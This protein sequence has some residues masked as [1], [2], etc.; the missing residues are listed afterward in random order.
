MTSGTH[1]IIFLFRFSLPTME[2]QLS[3]VCDLFVV[4]PMKCLKMNVQFVLL[5]WSLLRT[6]K[7]SP[8]IFTFFAL[9]HG[10]CF[11]YFLPTLLYLLFYFFSIL[12]NAEF[13]KMADL[14][15]PVPGGSNNN[16]YANVEL[17]LNIA[18]R[19]Q[20]QVNVN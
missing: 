13:I 8:L 19:N 20:V 5:L 10:L 14:Y 12:A 2:L 15:V 7:V 9:I 3:N 1:F 17:I 4:G 6:S 11:N 18:I 16:N